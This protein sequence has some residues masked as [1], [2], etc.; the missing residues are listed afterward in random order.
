MLARLDDGK[1]A[2]GSILQYSSHRK[3]SRISRTRAG[4]DVVSDDRIRG[5]FT[6]LPHGIEHTAIDPPPSRRFAFRKSQASE[7]FTLDN[8]LL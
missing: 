8:G 1:E 6:A 7:S 5:N 3:F 2:V 4:S